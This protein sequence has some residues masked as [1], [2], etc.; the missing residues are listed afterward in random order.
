MIIPNNFTFAGLDAYSDLHLVVNEVKMYVAPTS[1][2]VTQ[3]IPAMVGRYKL[4]NK[5]TYRQIDLDVT[6]MSTTDAER[7]D[8]RSIVADALF[9]P[10]DG[11]GE[12]VF[13]DD[14]EVTYYGQFTTPPQWARIDARATFTLTF[15]ANDPYAYLPQVDMPLTATSTNIDVQG[16]QPTEPVISAVVNQDITFLGVSTADRYVYLGQN[17]DLDA[18]QTPF[19]AETVLI[20]DAMN[21]LALWD[22]IT[23]NDKTFVTIN[24]TIDGGFS[25][26]TD[27]IYVDKN[28][29]GSVGYGSG[30]RWHG[31]CIR[32]MLSQSVD[33]WSI[34]ARIN[35]VP[36]AATE[37]GKMSLILLGEN[38]QAIGLLEIKDADM[39]EDV[40]L[41][42][43]IGGSNG[44]GQII[45]SGGSSDAQ[46]TH[47]VLKY[48]KV[49]KTE[50]VK[51]TTYVK[52]KV[53]GKWETVPDVY[54]TTD[55]YYVND[56]YYEIV[57][58]NNPQGGNLIPAVSSYAN[59]YGVMKLQKVGTKFTAGFVWLNQDL[60][61]QKSYRWVFNDTNN[62]YTSKLAGVAIW[63]AANAT[64]PPTNWMKWTDLKVYRENSGNT[65]NNPPV[66]AHAGD[67]IQIDCESGV[68]FKNGA[69][70]M[71]PLSLNSQWLKLQGG[72]TSTVSVTPFDSASWN[73]SY[74]PK[75][76]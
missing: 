2:Q 62:Q 27:V 3:E 46:Y 44:Q 41:A 23:E 8:F 5:M 14:P 47:Q 12:L 21:N 30:S 6:L 20:N 49:A 63:T 1:E 68:V 31:P 24:G 29:T 60:T 9:T 70:F 65:N 50:K 38:A 52:K 48:R 19:A 40:N 58:D 66:I 74:R 45:Y 39:R 11:D 16:T 75:M 55:T 34:E 43:S 36:S 64:I 17:I 57:T 32:R 54:Y 10:S 76:L 61:E 35:F 25:Q 71:T 59:V 69:R 56:P 7:Y 67:E 15:I 28:A 72:D 53:R 4:Q 26:T 13:D 22:V 37:Q 51:H 73:L 42:I 18:A 33:D